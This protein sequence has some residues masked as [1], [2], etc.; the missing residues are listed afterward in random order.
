MRRVCSPAAFLA[1]LVVCFVFL[2]DV[3][4]VIAAEPANGQRA[5]LQ[6]IIN[7][8]DKGEVFA[9]LRSGDVLLRVQDLESAG[10]RNLEGTR[11]SIGTHTYVALSSLAPAVT[12]IFDDKALVLRVMVQSTMQGTTVL[13]LTP[14]AP[15]GTVY[16]R[17]T[18]LFVNYAAETRGFSSYTAFGEAGL[19]LGG[20]L[21]SST[22]SRNEDGRVVRGLSA[23]TLND[24]QN[25]ARW[26]VGDSF[27]TSDLLGGSVFFAGISISRNFNLNPY[28]Y[29]FPRPGLTGTA[30][31]PSTI[32][33][34]SDGGILRQ[35][36]VAPG[37][38]ELQ[39]IPVSNGYRMNR[40]VIR[41]IFGR[42]SE[43]VSPFYLSTRVLQTGVSEYSYNVGF[44]R[45]NLGVDS[46]NYETPVLL[47][48]YRVGVTDNLT[49][50]GHVEA[51]DHV[52]N[53]GLRMTTRSILGE[54]D[55]SIA[56]SRADDVSGNAAALT[57]SFLRRWFS[58]GASVQ[59]TSAHYATVSLPASVDRAQVQATGFF[60]FPL[61]SRVSVNIEETYAHFR[62]TGVVRRTGVTGNIRMTENLSLFSTNSWAD[63]SGH[64]STYEVF[65]G[66]SYFF[67]Y[68]TTGNVFTQRQRGS[69]VEGIRL[70]RS[71]PVGPGL[72]YLLEGSTGNA[73][74]RG[75]GQLQYQ[76]QYG[77]YEAFYD[78]AVERPVFTVS[79]GVVA[80]GGSVH[81]TRAID[82]GF[83]LIRTPGVPGMRGYVNNQEVGRTDSR[84]ELVVPNNLISYYGNRIRINDQDIPLDYRVDTTEKTIA[85]PFRGGS[86]V[87]F[88]I[89]RLQILTGTLRVEADGE[90][91]VPTYGTLTVTTQD[92]SV[93]SPVGKNGEFYLENLGAGSFDAVVE[94]QT[95]TC[96]FTL[97][98]PS[99][100]EPF[101]KLGEIR[102]DMSSGGHR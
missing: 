71:L 7:E 26:T 102:C 10:I 99:A 48:R 38:F 28:F 100:T 41:D 78:S 46:W 81:A 56:G 21:L 22:V 59:V 89:K 93:E 31:T 51:S 45:S 15:T 91:H 36:S 64:R 14:T 92:G 61:G 62:D 11:E 3:A 88:P 73:S 75:V 32:S 16:T 72:G 35:E 43:I 77:R 57:Y 49:P 53:A 86:L 12:F 79:G 30:L 80:L 6:L 58:L 69:S 65:V 25:L 55:L 19:S 76:G 90:R 68:N 67:G 2:G 87:V 1:C 23:L 85:P 54:M 20:H 39:N 5:I 74:S 97:T 83:A 40:V 44:R 95:T 101:V 34:Y 13:D 37:Q 8:V 82:D 96:R 66:L 24:T 18:S 94:Y 42:E 50:G 98:V 84:G 17:D 60:G 47:A 4:A 29:S 27:A 63:A 70:Q 52:V 9:W 33:V